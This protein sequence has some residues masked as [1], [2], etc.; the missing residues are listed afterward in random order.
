[1]E[2]HNG[3]LARSFYRFTYRHGTPRWD[4]AEPH[5]ELQTLLAGRAP[6]RAL[7][8]GC[9]TGADVL[10]LAQQGW[11]AVGVDFVPEAIETARRRASDG[12]LTARFVVGDVT[13][14]RQEGV[15]GPFD[16]ILDTGC[17]HGIAAALRD[18]YAAEVAA[19]AAPGADLYV[20]GIS[21]P[22]ATWRLL[23][24]RG[25]DGNDLRRHFGA[26]FELVEERQADGGRGRMSHFGLYHLVGR[27]AA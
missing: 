19:V 22:P 6:G 9:G 11:D 7:D 21:D 12:G 14:L 15:E 4:S 2:H 24:A 18:S 20:A 13:R 27:Q 25:V 1:M 5:S 23:G 8:L 17:F 10:Y 16:L 26:D 3:R